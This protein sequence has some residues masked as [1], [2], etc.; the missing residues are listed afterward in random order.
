VAPGLRIRVCL[1]RKNALT[2]GASLS[3]TTVSR[4]WLI[5]WISNP[6]QSATSIVVICPAELWCDWLPGYCRPQRLAEQGNQ[7]NVDVLNG[8]KCCV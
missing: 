5:D 2:P 3:A 8:A 6:R 1:S 4:R 7:R